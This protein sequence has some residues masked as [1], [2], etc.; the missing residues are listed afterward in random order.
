MWIWLPFLCAYLLKNRQRFTLFEPTRPASYFALADIE[1]R[2]ATALREH[3]YQQGLSLLITPP[4]RDS[5][6]D[7]ITFSNVVKGAFQACHL[8]FDI[9]AD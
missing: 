6:I 3:Q 5:V 2:L 7:R 1:I 4:S 9:D 8:G